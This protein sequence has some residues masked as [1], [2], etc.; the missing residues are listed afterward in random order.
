MAELIS[1]IVPTYNRAQLLTRAIQSILAQT[2]SDLEV[3][4]VDDASTDDTQGQLINIKLL[5]QRISYLRHEVNQGAQVA[6]NTGIRA[7]R[8]NYIAFLDSDNEWLPSKLERQM[9]LF[10]QASNSLGVVYCGYKIISQN[11]EINKLIFPKYRGYIYQLALQNWVADTSTI[12]VRREIL[13]KIHGFDENIPAFQEWDLCIR[14]ARECEF[15]FVPKCLTLYHQHASP[16][17]SKDNLKNAYSYLDLVNSNRKEILHVCGRRTLSEHYLRSGLMFIVGDRFDL[18]RAN[19]LKS[20]RHY[21]LK[22]KAIIHFG[23][24]LLGE[25]TYRFLRSLRHG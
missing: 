7:A 8:G 24:S 4:V 13:E 18:A 25:D 5:D 21:P 9:A 16:S 1:V 12:V 19:F 10:A 14:L 20:I 17:I 6:R 22:I 11:E 3:I 2:Y 15:D 23:V